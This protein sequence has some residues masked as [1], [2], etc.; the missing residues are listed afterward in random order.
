MKD[1]RFICEMAL[2]V[3]YLISYIN[4]NDEDDDER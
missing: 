1:G 3:G 2:N 4:G